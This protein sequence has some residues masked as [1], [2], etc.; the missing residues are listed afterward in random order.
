M[1]RCSRFS[2]SKSNSSTRS[3]LAS[4]VPPGHRRIPAAVFAV[5]AV[6]ACLLSPATTFAATYYWDGNNNTAGFGTASGTWAAPTLG[7]LTSGW[8]TQ[9]AGTGVVNG[10]SITTLT[11]DSINFGNGATGLGAGTITVSG[12]ANSGS[13]TFASGSGAI[14]LSGGTITFVANPTVTVN[15]ATNTI[16]SAIGGAA[17]SFTK[18]GTGTLVLG[19]ANTYAGQT[20]VNAG[21][22]AIAGGQSGTGA[23]TLNGGSVLDLGNSGASGS[24]ASTVLNLSGGTFNYTRTDSATQSFS[25]TNL[26]AAPTSV[27]SVASGNTLNLGNIVRATGVTMDFAAVGAGTVATTTTNVGGILSGFT[28]GDTWA[29]GNGAGVAI[30]GLAGGSYTLS[31]VAGTTGSNYTGNN[32]DVDNS[33]GTLDAGITANSLRFSATGAN[34]L[35]LTGT[36]V[37]TTGGVLVGSGVGANLS[38]ITGGTLAGAA[39]KDLSVV[40]NN[41]AGALDIASNIANNGGATAINKAGA[42]LLTLS[43]NNTFSGGLVIHDGQVLVNNAGALNSTAGAENAVTFGLGSTG[44]LSLGGNNVVVRSLATNATVPGVAVVENASASLATLTVG[45][46]GN[47]ASTFAGVIQDGAG[48]G[49]LALAKAGTGTLTLSGNNTYTGGTTLN[50]GQL[51]IT[52]DANLGDT[53]GDITFAGN[54][55]LNMNATGFIMNAGRTITINPGVTATFTSNNNGK[56]F[57]G[58]LEG[59]GTL[60]VNHS[61]SFV[62]TNANSFTG[63]IRVTTANNS[64]Y[65]LDMYSLSDEAGDGTISLEN[66]SFRWFGS[67]GTKT[68]DNRQFFLGSS[69]GGSIYN[70]STDN[71]ALVISTNLGQSGTGTR[72]LTLG[73]NNS[74]PG[75]FA[76]NIGDNGASAVTVTKTEGNVWALGGTNTYSGIT[77]L[78]AS[79]TSGRVIFQGSQSLSPN[80][81]IAFNQVSSS[82]QSIS[83]L[84]DGVGTIDFV[85]PITFGGSN[86]SQNMNIFVGNNNT[87]NGGS[88][89][90]T[91]TN[92]TIEVG[93]ITFISVAGDTNTTTINAT[94]A[95]GYRLQTGVITLN[96]L[97]SRNAG[98]TTVTALNPTSASMTVASIT[99]ATGNT[100]IANDGVPVLRLAGTAS[101]NHVTG[102]ISNAPDYLTGQALSFQKQGTST[103]TLSGNNTYTGTTTISGGTLLINGDNSA[104]TGA[105]TVSGTGT[106][107]G[108]SGTIGGSTTLNTLAILSP[109]NSPGTITF[110][111]DLTLI[112]GAAAAGATAVFE[113]GDL[114]DVDGILTLNDDW[115]LALLSGFQDG[116]SVTLF[117]YGTA[118]ATLDLTPD[119]DI[120]GLGFTP[121]GP[122]TLTDTG[123]AIVLNG[124]AIVPEPD[125]IALLS[126]GAVLVG[127]RLARRRKAS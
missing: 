29:V 41:T 101:D 81:T 10:N 104:A 114:V 87:S 19:G 50:A 25:T 45:N 1:Q 20:V 14:V 120:S 70:R 64:A 79:G 22:L 47:A 9:N 56:Q 59:S 15:N 82:V 106:T 103:W 38:T 5:V 116:G 60:F 119:I 105:V 7:T 67:G 94:G 98:Q 125:T 39:S 34:T 92:S 63:A 6:W 55:T 127:L 84:D 44:T 26:N 24:L 75:T 33:A 74:A 73:G 91:T 113:G 111:Q 48:G 121:S 49:A 11:G 51:S 27:L 61:T 90:G 57:D 85:R 126:A 37:V 12:T 69:S 21:T 66:G 28:H 117:T 72:T 78:V 58:S 23:V 40:Q 3:F 68:F 124:I 107:L 30:S 17:T 4:L 83:L 77:N 110:A 2:E 96:N 52:S 97:V 35:S 16:D 42:G 123:S 102:V 100:G 93:S 88:S 112:G 54:S 46:S 8:T 95:N 80:T 36:N 53:T 65:G 32:I 118:G 122:L 108:G 89:S 43:G 18:A 76:G 62:F 71:S 109:G 13:M 115:N 86:T 99:M 31:S